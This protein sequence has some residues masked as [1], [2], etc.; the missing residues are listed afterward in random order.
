MADGFLEK[1]YDAWAQRPAKVTLRRGGPS[2]DTLLH[3]N[4]SH[5][6][7]DPAV[8]VG[9]EQLR[10]IVGVSTLLPSGHNAQVLRYRLVTAEDAPR[11]L[12]HLRFGGFLPEL[13]LPRPGEE[14]RA[15]IVICTTVPPE[16]AVWMDLGIAC[17]AMG[18]KAVELG[19]NALILRAFDPAALKV[20]LGL[21][22]DPVAVLAIGKGTDR[23][24]LKP[25][26]AGASLRYYRR[27]GVHFVPK[28]PLDDLLI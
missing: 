2:L 17:E 12:P 9:E 13:H 26:P 27:D 1:Q 22:L 25:T 11:L 4:R 23:I 14:P 19:L 28:L 6:G 7:F 18:L 8:P 24:F 15:F 10:A 5:R 21:P 20:E 3:N 16:P